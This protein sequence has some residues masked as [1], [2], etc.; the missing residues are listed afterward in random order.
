MLE[1]LSHATSG[2]GES[3][4]SVAIVSGPPS[5]MV[6]KRQRGQ[7]RRHARLTSNKLATYS[8]D[9]F[10]PEQSPS[11]QVAHRYWLDV[12]VVHRLCRL[13]S[14]TQLVMRR[15]QSP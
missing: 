3:D 5:L 2:C 8:C 1:M 9:Y 15:L 10:T 7:G 13:H 14:P 4:G 11:L 12:V 6:G